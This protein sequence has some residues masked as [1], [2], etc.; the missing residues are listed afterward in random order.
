[1]D[2]A[3]NGNLFIIVDSRL[4]TQFNELRVHSSG[5]A[6]GDEDKAGTTPTGAKLA[7]KY[8]QFPTGQAKTN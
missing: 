5:D 3:V 7:R 8:R 1:M 6:P 4:R 2:A